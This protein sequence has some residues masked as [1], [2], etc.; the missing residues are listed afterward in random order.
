MGEYVHPWYYSSGTHGLW[1]F[2]QI[3]YN[4]PCFVHRVSV[5]LGQKKGFPKLLLQTGSTFIH[6]FFIWAAY[7]LAGLKGVVEPVP[8]LTG[9]KAEKTLHMLPVHRNWKH[10]IG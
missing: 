1:E 3:Q 7:P 2:L 9:R 10:I 8:A 6:L 5:M 4:E